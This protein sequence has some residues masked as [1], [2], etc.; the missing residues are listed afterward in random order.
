MDANATTAHEVEGA[1]NEVVSR[2]A[3]V[4]VHNASHVSHA[5]IV[6]RSAAHAKLLVDF[7]VHFSVF[8]VTAFSNHLEGFVEAVGHEHRAINILLEVGSD[9]SSGCTGDDHAV[10][11]AAST[12]Q[13][14]FC[15]A[16][17]ERNRSRGGRLQ[18][19]KSG[20]AAHR[21]GGA[22]LSDN[23]TGSTSDRTN[24]YNYVLALNQFCG[25]V[26]HEIASAMGKRESG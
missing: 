16:I 23:W 15:V 2:I 11:E 24:T 21:K 4:I 6:E 12:K 10:R 18:R 22:T 9:R 14:E 26:E 5:V 1:F 3:L 25:V 17:V 20:S 13:V 7:N 19:I 8:V